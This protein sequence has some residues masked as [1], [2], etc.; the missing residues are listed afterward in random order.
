MIYMYIYANSCIPVY[1]HTMQPSA[2]CPPQQYTLS[3]AAIKQSEYGSKSA[4]T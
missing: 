3:N 1:Y 2:T 4:L